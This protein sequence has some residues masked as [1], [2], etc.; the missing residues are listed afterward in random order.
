MKTHLKK[1]D[2]II[3]ERLPIYACSVANAQHRETTKT[4]TAYDNKFIIKLDKK[5]FHIS[6]NDMDEITFNSRKAKYVL[7]SKI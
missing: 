5:W 6:K 7:I 2:K 3:V 1:G 4:I